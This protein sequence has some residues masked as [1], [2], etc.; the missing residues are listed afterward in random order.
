MK[1]KVFHEYKECENG[2]YTGNDI[3]GM[4]ETFKEID[5]VSK[6]KDFY[7]EKLIPCVID[8]YGNDIEDYEEMKNRIKE[9][10]HE[11]GNIGCSD[12]KHDEQLTTEFQTRKIRF[13]N[14]EIDYPIGVKLGVKTSNWNRRL[15]SNCIDDNTFE[16][17]PDLLD[18]NLNQEGLVYTIFLLK[19]LTNSFANN[20]HIDFDLLNENLIRCN[21]NEILIT[22]EK[23]SIV[24]SV[25]VDNLLGLAFWQLKRDILK[26]EKL[27]ICL[28][29]GRYFTKRVHN[30]KFCN[31]TDKNCTS[32]YMTNKN[33]AKKMWLDGCSLEEITKKRKR[34]ISEVT[35]WITD[36]EKN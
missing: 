9:L 33:R 16:V 2:F 28:N 32:T 30:A 3:E 10:I 6:D 11:Y 23:G 36:W 20:E 29:C 19:E 31:A 13:M 26:N 5:P 1:F 18:N 22:N 35:G 15:P 34:P 12:M 17:H 27:G 7:K 25:Y 24:P 8:K 4:E 21:V 14:M